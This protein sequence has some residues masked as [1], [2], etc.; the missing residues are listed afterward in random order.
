M[1]FETEF[2][3]AKEYRN[4]QWPEEALLSLLSKISYMITDLDVKLKQMYLVYKD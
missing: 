1:E 2:L 3:E 4:A